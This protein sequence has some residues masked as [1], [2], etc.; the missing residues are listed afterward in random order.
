MKHSTALYIKSFQEE[1]MMIKKF[2]YFLYIL[3]IVAFLGCGGSKEEMA[4]DGET[5]ESLMQKST[6]AFQNGDYDK[7]YQYAQLMLDNFPTSDLHIDAQL[8]MANTLGAK[9]EYEKQFDLLLRIL[10]ENIIPERVPLIYSQIAAFYENSAKWNPGTITTDSVD[11]GRAADFYKKA[12]F[13]PNSKDNSTKAY[14]LYRMAMMHA[15]L[16]N[17]ETASKA[18]QE[19][20]LTYPESPYTVLAR[21]KLS[22][23][24]N[25]E[26][27]PLPTTIAEP[28]IAAPQPAEEAME[29]PVDTPE[30]QP[31][32]PD[33]EGAEPLE[34][35]VGDEEEPSI[36]D[37]LQAIDE[38]S[39]E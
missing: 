7:S 30:E 17:I 2:E 32:I 12:V 38:D 21:T 26:E 5:P 23:P 14:A 15:K 31:T 33:T 18:Y 29:I 10:K 6:V 25:T 37:S 3:L 1:Q 22:D 19:L 36:L 9:E 13:Y 39:E 27:L 34:L 16:N 20:I 11:F 28:E 35:P 8:Q 4:I 24:S